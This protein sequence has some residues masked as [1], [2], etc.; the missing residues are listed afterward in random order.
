M[1]RPLVSIIIPAHN[2]EKY[3]DNTLQRV[4]NQTFKNFE[5]IVVDDGSTDSTPRIIFEYLKEDERIKLIRQ[6]NKGVSSARNMGLEVA[7]GKYVIFLDSDDYWDKCFLEYCV[8]AL[9][10]N[11]ADVCYGGFHIINESGKILHTH[12][13]NIERNIL[14]D[15]IRGQTWMQISGVLI[16]RKILDKYSLK[17]REGCHH[18]QDIEFLYKLLAVSRTIA[19][20]RVLYS[21]TR[22][23]SSLSSGFKMQHLH[24]HGAMRRSL[25]FIKDTMRNSEIKEM[26]I[27]ELV[28]RKI[29]LIL[30]NKL[31]RASQNHKRE[32]T[33]H[34]LRT[35]EI[36]YWIKKFKPNNLKSTAIFIFYLFGIMF[37]RVAWIIEKKMSRFY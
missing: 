7:R 31:Y 16:R 2:A 36:R 30:L 26:V 11:K 22:H 24:V 6:S 15:F 1:S 9:E 37:P 27:D 8:S 20:P 4:I 28:N 21:Y 35:P 14:L 17:F 29:P 3:L 19:I 13:P 25:R 5:V 10:Q 18:G 32:L 33:W 12:V 34:L 23:S